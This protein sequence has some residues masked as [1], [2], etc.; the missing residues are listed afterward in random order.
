[1][2]DSPKLTTDT[3]SRLAAES[4]PIKL[5]DADKQAVAALVN[6]LSAEMTAM[7]TLAVG[8]A[9]PAV[10]YHADHK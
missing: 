1:M 4:V 7:R 6:D 5:S 9:D 10:I 2:A 8:E 3:I